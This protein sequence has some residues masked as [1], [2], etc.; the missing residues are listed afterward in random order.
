MDQELILNLLPN[1]YKYKI[2]DHQIHE[3]SILGP[4]FDADIRVAGIFCKD[5]VVLFLKKLNESSGCTYNIQSG[6]ADKS[7]A[8]DKSQCL[9]RGFRKCNMN[10][11]ELPGKERKEEGKQTKCQSHINFQLQKPVTCSK[12]KYDEIKRDKSEFPLWMKISFVHNHSLHRAEFLKYRS[13]S[14]DTQIAYTELF[15]E[16]YTPSSAH[17]HIRQQLRDKYPD[18]WHKKFADK[19]I[20][21]SI[22]W[23][24]YWYQEFIKST[25][26]SRDGIDCYVKAEEMIKLFNLECQKETSTLDSFAKIEQTETEQTVVV[27][28]DPFMKRV[29]TILPQSAE[30]VFIDAT[31]NL[32][33]TDMKLFHLI[34]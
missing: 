9:L 6:R 8:T 24:Y 27:I 29:H 14:T 12:K 3:V 23:V 11:S 4:Q 34:W 18:S 25:L 17:N 33:R 21:P 16:G 15:E 7:A 20:L 19:S 10:V 22:F 31:S 5:D 1:E 13:I 30:I 32:D 28:L 2:V 26:G